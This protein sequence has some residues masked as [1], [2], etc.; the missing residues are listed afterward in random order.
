MRWVGIVRPP[1]P[2]RYWLPH[3]TEGE[4]CADCGKSK[5]FT[6]SKEAE[7]G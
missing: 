4:V 5:R 3:W 7:R 6:Q 2:H 1:C